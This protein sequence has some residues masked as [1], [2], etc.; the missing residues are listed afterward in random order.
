MK[1]EAR[2][3]KELIDELLSLR[4][5]VSKLEESQNKLRQT[6]SELRKAEE[7]FAMLSMATNDAVHDWDI[8]KDQ[9]WCN[10][11]MQK[12]LGVPEI[13]DDPWNWWI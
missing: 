11:G 4:L 6:A 3:K 9:L 2:T 7:R 12:A 5:K 1:D 8:V 10:E 13:I